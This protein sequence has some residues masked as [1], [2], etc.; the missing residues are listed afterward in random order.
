[1]KLRPMKQQKTMPKTKRSIK[2]APSPTVSAPQ[3][4]A[5]KA[6]PQET[7]EEKFPVA[8]AATPSA[9]VPP[10]VFVRCDITGPDGHVRSGWEMWIGD[11]C[12]GRADNK[13]LL[14]VSFQRLQSPPE[15]FHWREVRN[16]MQMR[17]R[18]RTPQPA[19]QK[20]ESWGWEKKEEEE[21]IV[22]EGEEVE[23]FQEL[24][25]ETPA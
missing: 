3:P 1:M 5:I 20:A 10:P 2:R 4:V 22:L 24:T 12:F 13:E 15:S 7:P 18:G 14:L 23:G 9:L 25:W 11:H 17:N 16:R 6:R 21:P 8:P 19:E